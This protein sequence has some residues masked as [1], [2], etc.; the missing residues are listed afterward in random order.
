MPTDAKYQLLDTQAKLL[1]IE[2]SLSE[3]QLLKIPAMIG[4]HVQAMNTK[5]CESVEPTIQRYWKTLWT[6][7][8]NE[9]LEDKQDQIISL[10]SS[11]NGMM[12]SRLIDRM[13][14]YMFI[15]RVKQDVVDMVASYSPV[16]CKQITKTRFSWFFDWVPLFSECDRM[17]ITKQLKNSDM[18]LDFLRQHLSELKT[19]LLM[20]LHIQFIDFY[21]RIQT[22]IIDQLADYY[23][24]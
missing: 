21:A 3:K 24:E 4:K 19:N 17:L 23:D 14:N 12:A 20:K 7:P 5:V 11:L 8:N 1:G 18:E 16:P 15:D 10:L 13:D 9:L 6:I 22:D 2:Q